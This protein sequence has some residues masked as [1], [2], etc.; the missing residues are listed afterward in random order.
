MSLDEAHEIC[1]KIENVIQKEFGYVSTIHPEP[2]T[3]E[4]PL[5]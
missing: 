3:W 4:N 1:T 2:I 5:K